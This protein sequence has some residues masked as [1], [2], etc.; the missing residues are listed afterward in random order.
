[1]SYEDEYPL[2]KSVFINDLKR[3]PQLLK[4]RYINAKDV[5]DQILIVIRRFT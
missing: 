2:H 3:I 4:P 5:H 1:M